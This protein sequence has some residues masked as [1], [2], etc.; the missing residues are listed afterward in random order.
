MYD[1]QVGPSHDVVLS[2][3][4]SGTP[5]LFTSNSHPLNFKF[6]PYYLTHSPLVP[7]GLVILCTILNPLPSRHLHLTLRGGKFLRYG[8]HEFMVDIMEG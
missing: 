2:S 6:D 3:L 4:A 7:Q 8:G 1:D 5:T